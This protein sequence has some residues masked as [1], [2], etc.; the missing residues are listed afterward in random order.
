M[1][2][3]DL[4]AKTRDELIAEL[5]ALQKEQFSLRLQKISTEASAPKSRQNAK[6]VRR[7]IARVK[8]ILNEQTRESHERKD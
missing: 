4:R 5:Q 7:D 8:T 1:K 6:Q 2:T 3:S